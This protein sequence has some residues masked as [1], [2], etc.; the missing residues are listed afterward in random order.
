MN[1]PKP[2]TPIDATFIANAA[3]YIAETT[4]TDAD[5][6]QCAIRPDDDDDEPQQLGLDSCGD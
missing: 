6:S 2:N 1:T 4:P 3:A 5:S